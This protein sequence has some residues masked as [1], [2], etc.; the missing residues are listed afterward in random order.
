MADETAALRSYETY[1]SLP[2]AARPYTEDGAFLVDHCAILIM[3][4]RFPT[5]V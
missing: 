3:N 4:C 1:K 2:A 5:C